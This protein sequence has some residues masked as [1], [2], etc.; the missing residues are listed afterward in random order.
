[1]KPSPYLPMHSRAFCKIIVLLVHQSCSRV[2]CFQ[3]IKLSDAHH[4]SQ[5]VL[6][7]FMT[8]TRLTVPEISQRGLAVSLKLSPIRRLQVRTP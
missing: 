6:F 2:F 1:M 3:W 8:N 5:W 7:R 4:S